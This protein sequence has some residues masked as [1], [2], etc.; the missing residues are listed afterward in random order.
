MFF[1]LFEFS[2]TSL[3]EG[4]V[5]DQSCFK[6]GTRFS[7]SVQ[8]PIY[9]IRKMATCR[10]TWRQQWGIDF[11]EDTGTSFCWVTTAGLQAEMM[12]D[13]SSTTG[14]SSAKPC[15]RRTRS[16]KSELTRRW[17]SPDQTVSC[18]RMGIPH[19]T[20]GRCGVISWDTNYDSPNY[21]FHIFTFFVGQGISMPLEKRNWSKREM[22]FTTSVLPGFVYHSLLSLFQTQVSTK[23][24]CLGMKRRYFVLIGFV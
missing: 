19:G 18:I 5:G 11:T 1:R 3:S 7:G 20:G 23:L 22:K 21:P 9:P 6:T 8:V 12:P 10:L 2:Q 14:L 16:S 15:W 17:G 24:V 13:R 4:C